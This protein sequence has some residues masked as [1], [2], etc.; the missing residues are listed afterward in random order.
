MF[1]STDDGEIALS[2][3][4][5]VSERREHVDIWYGELQEHTR[6]TPIRWSLA[7]QN[8]STQLIPAQPGTYLLHS[9]LDDNEFKVFRSTV[10]A[11]TAA[12]DGFFYPV[13]SD[14]V[15]DGVREAPPIL[16]PDG[17]VDVICD[18]SFE[19]FEEWRESAEAEARKARTK[20]AA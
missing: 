3:I 10:V 20:A 6:T 17:R 14:G 2:R 1:V 7:L 18:C 8:S 15:N 5:R 4:V 13:T 19:S 12:A 9:D 11:W 16:H